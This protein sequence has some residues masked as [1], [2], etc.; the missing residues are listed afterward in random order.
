MKTT[1]TSYLASRVRRTQFRHFG[2]VIIDGP[3][4]IKHHLIVV[5]DLTVHGD[6]DAHGVFCFGSIQVDGNVKGGGGAGDRGWW[7]RYQREC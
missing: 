2:D 3:V 1:T 7:H 5:G 4:G 6:L